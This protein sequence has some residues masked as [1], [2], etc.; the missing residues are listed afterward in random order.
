[1][2]LS[3][4]ALRAVSKDTSVPNLLAG[5]AVGINDGPAA[6]AGAVILCGLRRLLGRR[7]K[8]HATSHKHDRSD[9]D[10]ALP[11]KAPPTRKIQ[12]LPIDV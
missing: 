9:E 4:Y 6:I 5:A 7:E 12:I 3:A 11:A 1:M 10:K 2:A 8:S